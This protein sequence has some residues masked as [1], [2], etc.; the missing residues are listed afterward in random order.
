MKPQPPTIIMG[1]DPGY[2]RVGWAVGQLKAGNIELIEYGSILTDKKDLLVARY[3][4]IDI[5]L[6]EVVERCQPQEAGVESLFFSN[7][8]KTAMH[9][10]EARGVILSCLF[11][12]KVVI[13]EYT[14]LQ[15]KQAVTGNGKAE[16]SA[17]DKM[18]RLQFHLGSE[19][20]LD[21]VMDAIGIMVTHATR[22]SYDFL[23]HR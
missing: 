1:I 6:S 19:K 23:S 10:S 20:I 21:D 15:V 12:Q 17:L 9:V 7:N 16:K 11:R 18:L 8:Q 13:S 3:Q 4:Q 22:R 2:D 14:P 5:Q